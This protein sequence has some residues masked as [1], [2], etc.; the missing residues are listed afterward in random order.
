MKIIR[1][2]ECKAMKNQSVIGIVKRQ[3]ADG[4]TG[5]FWERHTDKETTGDG[6]VYCPYCG[7][8]LGGGEGE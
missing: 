6:I 8:K 2:H 3:F 7:E 5:W 1:E 4:T